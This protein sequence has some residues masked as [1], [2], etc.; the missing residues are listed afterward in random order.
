MVNKTWWDRPDHKKMNHNDNGPG[1]GRNY[2]ET[3]VSTFGR[4][5]FFGPKI[6]CFSSRKQPKFAKRLIF[7]WE[8]GTFLFAQ[9]FLIVARLSR[10]ERFFWPKNS[11]FSLRIRF[12]PYDPKFCQR[13]VCSPRRDGSFPTFRTIFPSYSRFPVKPGRCAKKTSPT[14]LWGHCLPVTV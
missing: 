1:L 5:V 10:R 12:L 2:G 9:L 8:K 13:P 11:V 4:K 7:I 14:P 3:A 6:C